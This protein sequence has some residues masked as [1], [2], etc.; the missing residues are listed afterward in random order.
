MFGWFKRKP[1]KPTGPFLLH[2]WYVDIGATWEPG[3]RGYT[4]TQRY[5]VIRHTWDP[6]HGDWCNEATLARFETEEEARAFIDKHAHLPQA[7]DI[8]KTYAPT[9]GDGA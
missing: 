4:A 9:K 1:P 7:F 2:R 8:V 6:I 3:D 5:G